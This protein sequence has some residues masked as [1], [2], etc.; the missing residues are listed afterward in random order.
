[1]RACIYAHV[2][3]RDVHARRVYARVFM[4]KSERIIPVY[5]REM[6]RHS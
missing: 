4:K 3:T 5:L 1:M 2:R 6:T